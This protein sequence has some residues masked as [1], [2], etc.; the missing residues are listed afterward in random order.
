MGF[1]TAISIAFAVGVP[2]HLSE[3]VL[4]RYTMNHEIYSRFR[5]KN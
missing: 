4:I 5:F 1:T 3:T 2:S